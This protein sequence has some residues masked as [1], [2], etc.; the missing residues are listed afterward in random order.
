MQTEQRRDHRC[1]ACYARIHWVY[2]ATRG[3]SALE[4]EPE[5]NGSIYI[6]ASG[7]AVDLP[8]HLWE[9]EATRW[10]LHSQRCG[11]GGLTCLGSAT[12]RLGRGDDRRDTRREP[13]GPE[14][15]AVARANGHCD[16]CGRAVH[17]TRTRD[18]QT[19][20]VDVTSRQ[21]GGLVFVDD[22]KTMVEPVI[23]REDFRPRF[24]NHH[25][26]CSVRPPAPAQV[27]R[28]MEGMPL[29]R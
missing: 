12:Q 1:R 18:G 4:P 29:S 28:S 5:P 6:L 7:H 9:V 15:F 22:S 14:L 24:R 11:L 3:W 8:V 21:A 13:P 27:D 10:R 2:H 26:A 20:P 16:G 25:T 19:V 17:W 23:D